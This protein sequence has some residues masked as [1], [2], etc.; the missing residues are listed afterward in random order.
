MKTTKEQ[1]TKWR[2]F[3]ESL[4]PIEGVEPDLISLVDDIDELIA[5]AIEAAKALDHAE[6]DQCKGSGQCSSCDDECPYCDNGYPG[7]ADLPARLRE[8]AGD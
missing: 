7:T 5:L 8:A 2:E 4:P 1:R 6:C 3:Y